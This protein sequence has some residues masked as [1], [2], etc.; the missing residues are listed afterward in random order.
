LIV[1]L[2][3]GDFLQIW[4]ICPK[5]TWWLRM[6]MQRLLHIWNYYTRYPSIFECPSR[7]ICKNMWSMKEI[8]KISL[9]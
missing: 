7:S 9:H 5:W 8:R 1:L 3:A 4:L 6:E 2:V